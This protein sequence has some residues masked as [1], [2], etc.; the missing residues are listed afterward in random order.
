VSFLGFISFIVPGIYVFVS[1][2]FVVQAV[3]IDGDRGF[4]PIGRS[5]RLVRGHWWQ[6]AVTGVAFWLAALVP[7]AVIVYALTPLARAVNSYA[8]VVF[9]G[10]LANVVAL[11]FLAIG[12]SLYYLE[13]RDVAGRVVRA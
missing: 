7:Q 1:W 9:A 10:A 13:L 4:A 2:F 6:S 11:P 12:A 3:V 5:A 8:I